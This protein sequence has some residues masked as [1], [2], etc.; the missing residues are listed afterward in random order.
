ML[1]V[2]AFHIWYPCFWS[3][4]PRRYWHVKRKCSA[5]KWM[6]IYEVCIGLKSVILVQIVYFYLHQIYICCM[7]FTFSVYFCRSHL[8]HLF[9][10]EKYS[11]CFWRSLTNLRYL[12]VKK[13]CIF[14][15]NVCRRKNQK[16]LYALWWIV[17]HGVSFL[18]FTPFVKQIYCAPPKNV[19]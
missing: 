17:G 5:N 19:R 18:L 3:T 2:L 12:T 13:L 14:S 15:V 1:D 16:G 9:S 11:E 10:C 4:D 8:R 6:G 7:N